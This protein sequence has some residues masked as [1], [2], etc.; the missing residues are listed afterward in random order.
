MVVDLKR[1]ERG[2]RL[3]GHTLTVVEQIPGLVK[4]ADLSQQLERSYWPS[5]NIP[6]F[7]WALCGS[8]R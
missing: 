4:W 1:L 2:Q 6:Y 7:R 5:Y 3:K 8:A